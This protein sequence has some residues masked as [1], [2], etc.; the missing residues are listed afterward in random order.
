MN[1]KL[2]EVQLATGR[3]VGGDQVVFGVFAD[4]EPELAWLGGE[5]ARTAGRL[6]EGLRFRGERDRVV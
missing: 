5:A 6:I 2:V 4:V 1:K 3:A